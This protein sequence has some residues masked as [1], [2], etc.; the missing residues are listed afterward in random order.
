MTRNRKPARM[1]RWDGGITIMFIM[2]RSI[3]NSMDD[4]SNKAKGIKKRE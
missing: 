1:A 3:V 4:T 2:E